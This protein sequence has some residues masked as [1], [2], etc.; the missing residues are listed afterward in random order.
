MRAKEFLLEDRTLNPNKLTKDIERFN[1]LVNNITNG[2]PLYKVDGTPV[3][4]NPSEAKRIQDVFNQGMFQG[5]I[6]LLGKDGTQYPLSSFLKT[7][8]YGG[9]AVPPGTAEDPKPSIGPSATFGHGDVKPG[10]QLTP[11]LALELGAFPAGQL[12][13]KI[14][15]SKH[16]D[17]QG[18]AGTA[19]KSM[20]E[21][22]SQG[23]LPTIPALK[24]TVLNNIQ[25]YAFEYLGVLQLISGTADFENSQE[26]YNHV[27][28]DLSS[29]VLYFPKSQSNPIADSYALVNKQTKN[30]IFI[31]SKGAKGGAPSSITALKIP[32]KM[33]KLIGK[34]PAISFLNVMQENSKPAWTQPFMAANWLEEN[35]PGSMGPL[36]K[37]LPFS[38]EFMLYLSS[39]LKTR[40]EGV[41]TD[42]SQIPKEYQQ[43]FSLVDS[44]VN[45]EHPLFYNLRYYVK[46][47]IH[48]AVKAGKIPNFSERMIELLG[49]NF[50]LLKTEK[51]GKPGSGH[52]NTLV[53][54]P[55]K[56]GGKVTL[57]HKDP[58]PKWDSAITWKLS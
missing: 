23:Q 2:A 6:T 27:G 14:M 31:S 37:F 13:A 9:L 40:N 49:H 51:V 36:S 50:V 7:K 20:A 30:T 5:R 45:S 55:S 15:A 25:N 29:L 41:P 32:D 1:N 44:S 42:I 52:F 12:A 56:V 35:I 53:R 38:D 24:A 46:D 54:W 48:R 43:L 11:E 39:I 8:D 47:Q 21:Q 18:D 17:Q 28:A 22:I 58:A 34:D 4:I 16:L 33:K 26:F 3:V 57:E 10:Q 19:V